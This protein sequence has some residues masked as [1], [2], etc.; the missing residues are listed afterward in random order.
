M[1]QKFLRVRPDPLS[2]SGAKD[3]YVLRIEVYPRNYK[4]KFFSI[5]VGQDGKLVREETCH[6]D[7][8]GSVRVTPME[9]A[10][11]KILK[12]YRKTHVP[13][14]IMG[15][16]DRRDK[17]KE[18]IYFDDSLEYYEGDGLNSIDPSE[19][20]SGKYAYENLSFMEVPSREILE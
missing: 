16:D 19:A 8:K 15:D 20:I 10:Y 7:E 18:D 4:N 2:S 11:D 12:S 9:D 14:N 1:R 17:V 3:L 6:F 13:R 5:K